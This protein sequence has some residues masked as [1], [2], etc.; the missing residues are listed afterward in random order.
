MKYA[1]TASASL[2][3][4]AMATPAAAQQQQQSAAD[5]SGLQE[6]V[7][8][9]SK[10]SESLS[11]TP[12]A[13]SVVGQNALDHSGANQTQELVADVPNLK[14]AT[15]GFAVRG[16]GSSNNTEAGSAT[17]ATHVDGVYQ[18]RSEF[19]TMPMFDVSRIEVLRGPQGT[20]YGRNATAGVVN[21]ITAPPTQKLGAEADVSYGNYNEFIARAMINLPV[22]DTLA[23]RI[24]AIRRTNDG[25]F[26]TEGSTP[27]NYDK[28]D[29]FGIRAT[30]LW[31]PTAALNWKVS[32]SYAQDK[33]TI[34][35]AVPSA[36]LT[37]ADQ[38][39]RDGV[40]GTVTGVTASGYAARS[41]SNTALWDPDNR[42]DN[43]E[44]AIRSN[45]NWQ[46]SDTVSL[47]WIAGYS[48][49][50][51][52][53]LAETYNP[54]VF[55]QD[56]AASSHSEEVD[57][58]YD[59]HRLHAVLGLYYFRDVQHNA[60][61]IN[62]R[63]SVPY[64]YNADYYVTSA[65]PLITPSVSVASNTPERTAESKAVFGQVTYDLTDRL[66]ATGGLRY[67]E[68]DAASQ[69]QYFGLCV[70]GTATPTF[71]VP[72]CSVPITPQ[73]DI[74]GL[75]ASWH[76]LSWKA[77]LEYDVT[78]ATLAYATVSTG[79]HAGGVVGRN[80][81]E[82]N[83]TFNPEKVTNYEAGIRSVLFNRKVSLN[84]TGFWMDYRDLQVTALVQSSG[85]TL[86]V[87]ANAA[88]ATIKG[89]EFEG[90][91]QITRHDKLGGFG[92][93]T[94]ARFDSYT[95]AADAFYTPDSG[96]ASYRAAIGEAALPTPSFDYSGH[97]LPNAPRWTMRA[98]YEHRFDLGDAGT[99]SPN[100][101]FNWQSKSYLSPTNYVGDAVPAYTRTDINLDWT[102]ANGRFSVDA[103]VTNLENKAIPNGYGALWGSAYVTYARPRL[104]G[105]R[106]GVKY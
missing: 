40:L 87:T 94:D 24:A 14:P 7:V 80:V 46:L 25:Y 70:Y 45:L 9:A 35:A 55:M 53:G 8:T 31:Q 63:S 12:L 29:Q 59:T 11:R 33:G 66:R 1:T 61:A 26:N 103:Y 73:V 27:E 4:L 96:Y 89:I 67:T 105:L 38:N 84:L 85:T 64:P 43:R 37:Y 95:N 62:G 72:G 44:W 23:I 50:F 36:F 92:T 3:A 10:R 15:N 91:W 81:P 13:I 20:L 69:A 42:L 56:N 78:P 104:Y 34:A 18:Q 6:I 83:W 58:K 99:L 5:G 41:G 82:A 100:L 76:N 97:S 90:A 86:P 16:V 52:D 47:S 71:A 57:F 49:F 28:A 77:G 88:R 48:R 54:S 19:M 17:V 74:G 101:A 98:T 93:Y 51:D 106:L 65:L 75:S 2:I 102:S 60:A 68:D 21:I 30:A 79:Y 39:I 22:S 32:F